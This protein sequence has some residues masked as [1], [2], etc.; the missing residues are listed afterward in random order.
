MNCKRLIPIALSVMMAS[1]YIPTALA[2]DAL[3]DSID[4]KTET[5]LLF[6][7]NFNDEKGDNTPNVVGTSP[8]FAEGQSGKGTVFKT[9][10]GYL[11]FTNYI[12]SGTSL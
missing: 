1:S 3:Q 12:G 5:L 11:D 4:A 9:N 10:G 8:T 6:E 2:D 7:D